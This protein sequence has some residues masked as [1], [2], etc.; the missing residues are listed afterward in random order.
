VIFRQRFRDGLA[1][2]HPIDAAIK[3][4]ASDCLPHIY[5]VMPTTAR[6]LLLRGGCGAGIPAENIRNIY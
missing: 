6:F 5:D 4:L 3:Y 2:W 1:A